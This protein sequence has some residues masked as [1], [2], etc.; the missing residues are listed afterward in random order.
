M[1]AV[2]GTLSTIAGAGPTKLSNGAA[3][4]PADGTKAT[5]V[6]FD[7]VD[8]LEV[9]PQGRIYVGDSQAGLIVRINADGTVTFVAGDQ[10]RTVEPTTTGLPANQ[11]R[12]VD[13]Y[14]LAFDK[15]GALLVVGADLLVK[16]DGVGS[17]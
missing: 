15:T 11:T 1:V 2:D 10:L 16:V 4:F 14:G 6:S 7:E 12:F 3:T 13:A 8:A 5:D 17:A 9:D